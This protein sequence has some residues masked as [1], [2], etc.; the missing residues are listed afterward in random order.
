MIAVSAPTARAAT[1]APSSTRWGS[2]VSKRRSLPLAGSPSVPLPTTNR[3][4][5]RAA[6]ARIF[7]AT[8]KPAPPRPRRPARSIS[9]IR[10]SGA[11]RRSSASDPATA[12]CDR[13]SPFETS[14][15]S[16]K[17]ARQE[18]HPDRRGA[19]VTVPVAVPGP[20][21]ICRRATTREP[22]AGPVTDGRFDVR[23]V[24]RGHVAVVPVGVG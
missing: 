20:E 19:T 18:A 21:A 24:K 5:R 16:G 7:L 12:R 23:A 2:S 6:T 17:D 4:P 14:S 3:G 15:D 11:Q 13:R 1:A 10:R 22:G 8:G 9:S